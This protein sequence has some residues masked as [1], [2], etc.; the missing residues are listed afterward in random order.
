MW[1]SKTYFELPTP[2]HEGDIEA[3]AIAGP[4]M[5][6]IQLSEEVSPVPLP[7]HAFPQ[8]PD[9]ELEQTNLCNVQ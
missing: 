4:T 5:P 2:I 9:T 8:E 7:T 1:Q 3:E 6:Q